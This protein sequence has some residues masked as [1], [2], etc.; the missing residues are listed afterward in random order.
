MKRDSGI[1]VIR[2]LV[3]MMVYVGQAVDLNRRWK[4]HQYNL[5]HRPELCNPHLFQ[6]WQKYGAQALFLGCLSAVRQ[7]SLINVSNTGLTSLRHL[8]LRATTPDQ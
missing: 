8:G 5:A 4:H 1:Y 3:S 2:C 7:V 6:A